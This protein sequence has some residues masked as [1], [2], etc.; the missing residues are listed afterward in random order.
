[1]YP[2]FVSNAVVICGSARTSGHNYAFLEGPIAALTNSVDYDD[3][4]YKERGIKP[5]RGLRAFTRAYRAWLHSPE[6]YREEQ[7]RAA[8]GSGSG[9]VGESMDKTQDGMGEWDPEDLLIL[10]K[11]WQKGD[12]GV[13]AEQGGRGFKDTLAHVIKARVLVMP[14]RTDQYFR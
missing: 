10:A 12:I 11:M 2:S 14:S 7:W 4:R 8:E 3:G 9:S 13:F 5:V 6:W 1:M